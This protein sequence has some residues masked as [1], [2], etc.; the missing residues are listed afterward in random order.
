MRHLQLVHLDPTYQVQHLIPQIFHVVDRQPRDEVRVQNERRH[1]ILAPEGEVAAEEAA[2]GAVT[3]TS[4]RGVTSSEHEREYGGAPGSEAVAHDSQSIGGILRVRAKEPVEDSVP[5]QI[6]IYPPAADQYSSVAVLL[7]PPL[8]PELLLPQLIQRLRVHQD[9]HH[10]I[11]QA[12]RPP[13]RQNDG[14]PPVIDDDAVRSLGHTGLER[15]VRDVG[16]VESRV[17]EQSLL[18]RVADVVPFVRALDGTDSAVVVIVVGIVAVARSSARPASPPPKARAG[19]GGAAGQA[20]DSGGG[21][22][23]HVKHPRVDRQRVPGEPRPLGHRGAIAFVVPA[24]DRARHRRSRLV[25]VV[26]CRG[27]VLRSSAR[28]GARRAKLQGGLV[29]RM[30]LPCFVSVGIGVCTVLGSLFCI[31]RGTQSC[32]SVPLFLCVVLFATTPI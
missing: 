22:H 5:L 15:R 21:T 11:L 7:P 4:Q 18:V 25:A 16:R 6:L 26:S 20:A 9:V 17:E 27:G 2:R 1:V 32:A 13:H 28:G 14:G 19:G 29:A 3:Q 12:Q 24:E 31:V 8:E 10:A 30:P 23:V